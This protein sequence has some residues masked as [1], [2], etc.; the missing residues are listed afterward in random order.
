[1]STLSSRSIICYLHQYDVHGIALSSGDQLFPDGGGGVCRDSGNMLQV[2]ESSK[3]SIFSLW[4]RIKTRHIQAVGVPR[5]RISRRTI[6]FPAKA[7]L[8][9]GSIINHL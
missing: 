3:S 9:G 8:P 1:M 5:P 7:N 6:S 2:G 4:R